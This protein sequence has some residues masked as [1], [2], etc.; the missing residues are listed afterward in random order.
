MPANDTPDETRPPAI[1]ASDLP[2]QQRNPYPPPYDRATDGRFRR[3]LGDT[4]GLTKFG[5]NLTEL[6][7]GAASSLRHWH[8]EEDEFVYILDGT[9]TLVTDAGEQL[10]EPGMCAGFPA[11]SGDG[12]RLENR[13]DGTVVYLEIGNRSAHETVHYP[14]VDLVLERGTETG[15]TFRHRDGTPY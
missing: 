12:H 7:P 1:R 15:M 11:N 9:P 10:L 5:V 3:V 13:S 2:T 6:A 14:D 8:T 4:L